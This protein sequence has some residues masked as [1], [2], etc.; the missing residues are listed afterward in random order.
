[1]PDKPSYWFPAKRYG[2]GW[3]LPTVW[4]GWVVMVI[5]AAL[6]L[7]GAVA[8]L[9]TRGP[10]AYVAYS[11]LLCLL[12]VAVCWLKGERPTWRWGGR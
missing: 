4:Q 9:P 3:G 8:L 12:L 1:M 11:A 6:L 10:A 7:V 2:W 5:F